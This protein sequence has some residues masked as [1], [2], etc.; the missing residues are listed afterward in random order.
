MNRWLYSRW[1]MTIRLLKLYLELGHLSMYKQWTYT[2]KRWFFFKKQ[3]KHTLRRLFYYYKTYENILKFNFWCPP[4]RHIDC[5]HKFFEA[6]IY[7]YK[8]N[9]VILNFQT[10]FESTLISLKELD[11]K[12]MNRWLYSRQYSSTF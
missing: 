6:V 11:A 7:R 3:W 10:T 9:E 1:K 8:N 5:L 4:L 12:P 2:I